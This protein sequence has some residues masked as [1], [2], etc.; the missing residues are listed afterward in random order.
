MCFSNNFNILGG[1]MAASSPQKNKKRQSNVS[2][3]AFAKTVSNTVN[4]QVEAFI[5]QRVQQYSH[6]VLQKIST[7]VLEHLA[8]IQTR[9]LAL[10][11][12]LENAAIISKDALAK[13]V[14]IQEDLALGYEEVGNAQEG[15]LVRIELFTNSDTSTSGEKLRVNS[16][17]KKVEG[18]VQTDEVLETMLV[19][20]AVNE[21][22]SLELDTTPV[23]VKIVKISRKKGE[24]GVK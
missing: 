22:V 24:E 1:K 13:A 23:T 16:L 7:L 2:A 4:S 12:L 9:Q 6:L 14:T 3:A 18:R 20:K 10:E 15:D 17:L 8:N 21:E 19:G 11:S 5:E